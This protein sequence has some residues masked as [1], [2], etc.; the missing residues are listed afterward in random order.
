MTS[1]VFWC[2]MLGGLVLIASPMVAPVLV[3]RW[4]RLGYRA[5][6]CAVQG[7]CVASATVLWC[8]SVL[9]AEP[10]VLFDL[11]SLV[12]PMMIAFAVLHCLLL[13]AAVRSVPAWSSCVKPRQST[14]Q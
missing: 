9:H 4:S 13:R 8:T 14:G 10:A 7:G 12:V 1:T 11:R 2:V 5:A 6:W 3:R